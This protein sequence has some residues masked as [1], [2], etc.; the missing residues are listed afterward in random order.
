M[1]EDNITCPILPD[2]IRPEQYIMFVIQTE[3]NFLQNLQS[4]HGE[5]G[6]CKIQT[7]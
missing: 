1:H 7:I 4:I 3:H 2:Y 6:F 5:I